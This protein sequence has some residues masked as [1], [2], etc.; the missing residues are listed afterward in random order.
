[1]DKSASLKSPCPFAVLLCSTWSKLRVNGAFRQF[2]PGCRWEGVPGSAQGTAPSQRVKAQL[3]IRA[4]W[5]QSTDRAQQTQRMQLL[6]GNE[7]KIT[8]DLSCFMNPHDVFLC[9][10]IFSLWLLFPNPVPF[11]TPT[12]FHL[13]SGMLLM[14]TG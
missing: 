6:F 2:T 5:G 1:M 13:C 14:S 8:P 7:S 11:G 4:G 10:Y 9:V 12:S 3:E